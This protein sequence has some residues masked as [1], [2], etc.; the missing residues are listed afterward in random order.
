MR[1]QSRSSWRSSATC[2]RCARSRPTWSRSPSRRPAAIGRE[3]V[4]LTGS[5]PRGLRTL[6][7]DQGLV[8]LVKLA[9]DGATTLADAH[10]TATSVSE[11]IR[12][13]FPDVADVV[14]HTEP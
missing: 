11:R 5:P 8:V 2:P 1:S 7:T 13:G 4:A 14:V 9:L 3:I 12:A 6:E 10:D